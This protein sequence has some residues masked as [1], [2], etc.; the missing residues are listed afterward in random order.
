MVQ[1]TFTLCDTEEKLIDAVN[2]LNEAHTIF[3][4]CEGKALGTLEGRLSLI[5]LGKL[6][7]T[8]H[9]T[10]GLNIYLVD[11]LA[12]DS[13]KNKCIRQLFIILESMKV[14]KVVFDGRMDASELLH[15]HS[16]EL[17]CVIDLQVADI[18]SRIKCEEGERR[19]TQR[20]SG[21]VPR[22][23]LSINATGYKTVHRLNGLDFALREHGVPKQTGKKCLDHATW[24][25]RPLTETQQHYAVNDIIQ[26]CDLFLYFQNKRFI[27]PHPLIEQSGRYI[28]LHAGGR[29]NGD[30]IYAR[31]PLLHLYTLDQ[32][33]EVA[34]LSKCQGCKRDLPTACFTRGETTYCWV[35]RAAN[36]RNMGFN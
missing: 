29:P 8:D 25:Q 22:R 19:R 28:R 14:V 16:V 34:I 35:C 30:S 6:V 32:M 1:A 31:N 20:L 17:K 21:V 3:L 2:A 9:G 24:L 15:G 27:D 13:E 5:S 23:E 33:P 7:Q 26:I 36:L 18:I 10:M 12:F 11:I 4:D